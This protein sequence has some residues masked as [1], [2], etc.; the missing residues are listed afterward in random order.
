MN[1]GPPANPG[2]LARHVCED[3]GGQTRCQTSRLSLA[4]FQTTNHWMSQKAEASANRPRDNAT[5]SWSVP[6]LAPEK[7]KVRKGSREKILLVLRF[8]A[9]TLLE[10]SAPSV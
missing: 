8:P 7:G 10:T 6:A 1:L 4:H 9:P 5:N 3:Q 2:I